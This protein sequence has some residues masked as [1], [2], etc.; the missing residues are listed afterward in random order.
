VSLL[1]H[2]T[3]SATK[4]HNIERNTNQKDFDVLP[5]QSWCKEKIAC[6]LKSELSLQLSVFTKPVEQCIKCMLPS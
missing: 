1:C 2:I 5:R 4:Q 3:V 6:D